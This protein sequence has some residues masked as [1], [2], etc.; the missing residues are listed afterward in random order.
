LAGDKGEGRCRYREGV[1]L[2]KRG[3]EGS[4]ARGGR[5]EAC[6]GGEVVEGCDVDGESGKLGIW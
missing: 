1:E 5:G 3:D 2:G 6:S 4:E